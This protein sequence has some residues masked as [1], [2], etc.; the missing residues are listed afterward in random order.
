[1]AEYTIGP[2]IYRDGWLE[3]G[4]TLAGHEH[5]FDHVTHINTGVALV[6][7]KWPDGREEKFTLCGLDHV[8]DPLVSAHPEYRPLGNKLWIGAKN[9]HSFK[10]L[11]RVHYECQFV[12][13]EPSTGQPAA[14]WNG[15]SAA[16][17]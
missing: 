13:R 5:N 1:M 10:A 12:A 4:Q 17:G 8:S 6:D 3:E 9:W 16:S 14:V 7:V 15:W 11:T 2:F